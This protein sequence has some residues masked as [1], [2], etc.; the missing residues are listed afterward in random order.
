MLQS[1]FKLI[2]SQKLNQETD[3][4]SY[5]QLIST[6]YIDPSENKKKSYQKLY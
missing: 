5:V 2:S 3:L 1:N 6:P 4:K